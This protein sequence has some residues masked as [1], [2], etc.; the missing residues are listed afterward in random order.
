MRIKEIIQ[1]IEQLAPVPLQEDY[2]NSG[3]QVGDINKE[4][5]GALLAIDITE[6]VVDEAVSLGCNLIISHHPLAFKPFKSLTGKNYVERC[7]MKAIK[8][9]VVIYAAH[10]NLDNAQ[11]GV[12][13]KLAEMLELENVKILKPKENSLLKFV[14]T[15]PLQHADSVRN[16]L[17]NA[18]AGHIGNYDSCSYN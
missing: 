15:V 1:S 14:T 11:G 2:D 13:Y 6:N 3:I 12:N 4:A 18:G 17:F 9:D 16:A 10:T 8:N 5:T 7:L